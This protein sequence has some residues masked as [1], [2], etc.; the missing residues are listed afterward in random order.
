MKNKARGIWKAA[1]VIL[2][3][4]VLIGTVLRLTHKD[5]QATAYL[6]AAPFERGFLAVGTNGRIDRI[7]I[8]GAVQTLQTTAQEDFVEICAAGDEAMAV[9][10]SGGIAWISSAGEITVQ[11]VAPSK[12][13]LSIANLRGCWL[14]GA[15]KGTVFRSDDGV[16]WSAVETGAK[17]DVVGL[18]ATQ[19]R[20][21]GVTSRGEVICTTDQAT[22]T[23]LDYNGYYGKAVTFTGIE[24]LDQMFWAYGTDQD[25]RAVVTCSVEGGVWTER[26]LNIY[27]VDQV[28]DGAEEPFIQLVSD[29]T[30]VYAVSKQ[31]NALVLPTCTQCNIQRKISSQPICAAAR[32][33][34]YL[35]FAGLDYSISIQDT[36]ELRQE[37]IKA[38]AARTMQ[39]NGAVIIDV[40]SEEEY[41]QGH[42]A[43]SIHMDVS[44][45][46]KELPA[47]YPQREQELIF[48]C[49]AGKR[50]QAALE[51]AQALGYPN[52]YNLGKISDWPYDL[53]P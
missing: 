53:E 44:E 21:I 15:E 22:W 14:T 31:G 18:A 36:A 8:D 1:L 27:E 38:D 26:D 47:Q 42:I 11:T 2:V 29:G 37:Y 17:G 40:R 24:A 16:G 34:S 45:V 28:I 9:G 43:G 4:A 35:M 10:N 3:G 50:S 41:V 25:G 33:D 30:Q 23:V 48:Y 51:T 46:E 6:D 39:Q 19:E 49:S 20:C 52:V 7:S 32:N 5:A 12:S 13:L